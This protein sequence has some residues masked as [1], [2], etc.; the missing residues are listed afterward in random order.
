MH[1]DVN[2]IYDVRLVVLSDFVGMV[3]AVT[4]R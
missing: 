1:S 4:H 2:V 3:L